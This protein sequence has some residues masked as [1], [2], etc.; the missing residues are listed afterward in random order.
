MRRDVLAIAAL[1]LLLAGPSWAAAQ[2]CD[3]AISGND[4]IQY[5]KKE[6]R[7]SSSCEQVTVTLTHTGELAANIMGHNWVLTT[8]ENYMP[9]AQAGQ[10]AGPPNYLPENDERVIAATAV[11]GGGEEVSVTFD[12]AGLEPGGDYTFF[13]SFP[14]HFVLMNGKFIVE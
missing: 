3:L 13:C 4:Q 2:E 6:M 10:S 1:G 8:T 11:I 5:D 9:V 7:V 12:M 14:G